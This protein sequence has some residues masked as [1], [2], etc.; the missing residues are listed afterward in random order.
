[1]S[2]PDGRMIFNVQPQ[3]DGFF[4]VWSQVDEPVRLEYRSLEGRDWQSLIPKIPGRAFVPA[5]G[6]NAFVLRLNSADNRTS[7]EIHC[8]TLREKFFDFLPRRVPYSTM[9]RF[10]DWRRFAAFAQ[11]RADGRVESA[12]GAEIQ[13]ANDTSNGIYVVRGESVL[14]ARAIGRS[15]LEHPTHAPA[16][17]RAAARHRL[18]PATPL[19]LDTVL[20]TELEPATLSD[21]SRSLKQPA[22]DSP[23]ELFVATVTGGLRSR[24]LRLRARHPH[25]GT[26]IYHEGHTGA[27]S[28][29]GIDTVAF[30]LARG[31]DV[32]C[33]D[34]LLCGLNQQDRRAGLENHNDLARTTGGDACAPLATMV[35][36]LAALVDRLTDEGRGPIVIAGRSGGGLMSY[37][38]AALDPRIVAS[39][40]LAG[41]VPLSQRLER[42]ETDL[43]DYEQFVPE[44][45]D[46]TRHEDLMICA[47]ERRLLLIYN[48]NDT[49]CFALP[50][51]H[52]LATF[53]TREAD[54]HRCAVRVFIDPL[55]RGHSFGPAGYEEVARF[56]SPLEKQVT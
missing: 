25:G 18:W 2:T 38:Y 49:D 45:F 40:A 48:S 11:S 6:D 16:N 39:V 54:R 47:G 19:K 22:A 34:M 23:P 5:E 28:S 33:V 12:A 26:A 41:G 55:H 8:R 37:L 32:C 4:C 43:G 1:M 20:L 42:K 9:R 24:I 44:F 27:G 15:L 13:P 14:F 53:L 56:L 3:T 46:L 21:L 17:T 29:Q 51:N 35:A 36:P 31:W 10:H 30:L 50:V 52:P 7:D